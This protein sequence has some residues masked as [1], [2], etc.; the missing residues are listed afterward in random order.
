MRYKHM[1]KYDIKSPSL[2]FSILILEI[3]DYPLCFFSFLFWGGGGG[4]LVLSQSWGLVL[5]QSF[6]LQELQKSSLILPKNMRS[7]RYER[8]L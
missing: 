6:I 8:H 3:L 1:R 2:K 7:V 5:S 4:G